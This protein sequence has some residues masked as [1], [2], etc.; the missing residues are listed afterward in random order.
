MGKKQSKLII[1]ISLITLTCLFVYWPGAQGSV[2]KQKSIKSSL[3]GIAGY[4]LIS[5]MPLSD[6]NA[7]ML[8]LD[9]YIQARYEKT[10]G[11]GIVD[12]YV[13]YYYSLEKLNASHHPLVCFPSQ[14][15]K[16]TS[17][18]SRKTDFGGNV[19]TYSTIEAELGGQKLLVMYW[20][21]AGQKSA[22]TLRQ[23]KINAVI[24]K[25][26]GKNGEHAFVRIIVP[27]QTTRQDAIEIGE[28]FM[29]AF[30]PAFMEYV[31]L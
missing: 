7:K 28:K 10:D 21:Q 15:W 24:N 25:F 9:D 5:F 19:I 30:Y 3:S 1:L 17:P 13:G 8:D 16:V 31:L 11:K 23:N 22:L 4:R 6:V 27:L 26:S 2:E 14:G 29:F 20:F 18:L 12:L